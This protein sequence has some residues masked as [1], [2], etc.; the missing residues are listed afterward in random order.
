MK[1]TINTKVPFVCNPQKRCFLTIENIVL[2]RQES[3]K[4]SLK[5]EGDLS[6][7]PSFY[8]FPIKHDKVSH[9][10]KDFP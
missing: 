7:F 3:T 10:D 1:T 6:I 4:F 5:K 9:F 8:I 2:K